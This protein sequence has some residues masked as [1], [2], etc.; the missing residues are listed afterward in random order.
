[1][2]TP[3]REHEVHDMRVHAH[4]DTTPVPRATGPAAEPKPQRHAA[5]RA[6]AGPYSHKHQQVRHQTTAD[7]NTPDQL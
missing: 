2:T 4:P 5:D 3:P 7:R 6:P 1:M